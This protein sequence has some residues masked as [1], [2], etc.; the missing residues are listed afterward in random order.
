METFIYFVD[1]G[2]LCCR[3]QLNEY[4]SGKFLGEYLMCLFVCSTGR[5]RRRG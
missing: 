5:L 4:L 2:G 1:G 3:T